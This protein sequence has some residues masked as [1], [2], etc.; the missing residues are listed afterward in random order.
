M[1]GHV[2]V[3][4]DDIARLKKNFHAQIEQGVFRT[5]FGLDLLTAIACQE[6]ASIWRILRNKSGLSVSWAL[7]LCVGGALD[8]AGGRRAF[9]R[10]KT[11]L[12]ELPN[13]RPRE[14]GQAMF[15][16][17]RQRLIDMAE[18]T[19]I[20]PYLRAADN[21][22]KTCHAFDI[23]LTDLEAFL[24][25]P[26][27][28]LNRC[29]RDFRRHIVA[30]VPETEEET[31]AG[32]APAGLRRRCRARLPPSISVMLPTEA[33]VGWGGDSPK[34]RSGSMADRPHHPGISPAGR[35]P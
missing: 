10:N 32:T 26:D 4:N 27:Y 20:R 12:L 14:N 24:E 35:Q 7:E 1:F 2:M 11:E 17:A 16:I 23:F 5:L 18:Q 22:N 28:F 15:D 34:V 25:Q 33:I 21:R 8:S 31:A 13:S 9:P 19:Q 30:A 6:T 29:W 3:A